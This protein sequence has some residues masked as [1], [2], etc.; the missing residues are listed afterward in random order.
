MKLLAI[1]TSSD[2]LSVAL[3]RDGRTLREFH[4]L[5]RMNH[6]RFLI[7]V[8]DALLKKAKIFLGDIDGFAVSIGPGSFTGLRIGLTTVKTLAFCMNKPVVAVPTL[9]VIAEQAKV[10]VWAGSKENKNHPALLCPILDAK[11]KKVYACIY[12]WEDVGLRRITEY[13]LLS[14]DDLLNSVE[15]DILFLGSGVDVYKDDIGKRNPYA[16]CYC[17]DRWYPRASIVGKIGCKKMDGKT[18]ERLSDLAPLYLYSKE[19]DV[20]GW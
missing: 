18:C 15:G 16:R 5:S 4:R 2:F 12:A 6:S 8:M 13:M 17:G 9:D 19:C 14:L 3:L 1:D 10:F 11:K 7:P 20:T